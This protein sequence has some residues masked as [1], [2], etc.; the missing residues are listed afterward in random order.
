MFLNISLA[1]LHLP[2]LNKPHSISAPMVF[3]SLSIQHVPYCSAF[4]QLNA[5]LQPA[6]GFNRAGLSFTPFTS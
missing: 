2:A 3:C 4:T 6:C 5:A 1:L